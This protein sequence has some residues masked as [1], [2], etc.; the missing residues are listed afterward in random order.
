MSDQKPWHRDP[1]INYHPGVSSH[2]NKFKAEYTHKRK[3]YYCKL[4]D[5][6]EAAL[7]A[8]KKDRQTRGF[9]ANP[10]GRPKKNPD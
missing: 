6:P 10:V 1:N 5:T 2:H 3:R 7:E 4:H 9:K 8:I